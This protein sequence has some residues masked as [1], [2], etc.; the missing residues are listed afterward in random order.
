MKGEDMKRIPFFIAC[1]VVFA[2]GTN[3]QDLVKVPWS[4]FKT[5]YRENIEREIRDSLPKPEKKKP[6]PFVYT[7]DRADFNLALSRDK[8]GGRAQISGRT[9]SG[10]PERIPI[11]DE[12]VALSDIG[13]ISGGILLPADEIKGAILF[14]P[15]KNAEFRINVSFLIPVREDSRSRFVSFGTS[16]GVKNS[17]AFTLPSGCR[18]IDATGVA[19]EKGT[20]HFA[21]GESVTVRFAEEKDLREAMIPV[22]DAFTSVSIHGKR[23]FGETV[24]LPFRPVSTAFTLKL[25]QGSQYMSSSLK[26]SR[27]RR[28]DDVSYEI[29]LPPKTRDGFS[30]QFTLPES[31]KGVFS[32]TLPEIA[33]N[34][35]N[36]GNFVVGVSDGMK[37]EV[38]GNGLVS[39][40]PVSKLAEGL[41]YAAGREQYYMRAPSGGEL[42]VSAR[43]FAVGS[44]PIEIDSFTRFDFRGNRVF[45]TTVFSPVRPALSA[46]ILDLPGKSRFVSSSLENSWIK[47]LDETSYEILLPPKTTAG[48][49]VRFMVEDTDS[50]GNYSMNLPSIRTNNGKE[51]IFAI[52]EPDDL[53][54]EVSGKGLVS[55]IPVSK[56]AKKFADAAGEEQFYMSLPAGESLEVTARRYETVEAPQVVLDSVYFFTSFEENGGVMSILRMTVP[57]G[58]GRRLAVEPLPGAEIWSVMVNGEKR[59]AYADEAGNWIIPLA[60]NKSSEVEFSFLRKNEKLGLHGKIVAELPKTWLPARNVHVGVAMPARVQLLSL[61]GP[62]NPANGEKWEMPAS[63]IGQRYFF[64]RSFYKGEGMKLSI[65]YKEPVSGEIVR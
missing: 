2:T 41:R 17:L 21:A 47:K 53:R 34:A 61:E 38:S 14:L 8:A 19:D 49:S 64:S 20:R 46:F 5:I 22:I 23:I 58:A 48:F 55:R 40:I 1:I 43:R 36:E 16:P 10:E 3:A 65:Y 9:I 62:A 27:I 25:P 4:E 60:K 59:N 56:L 35:G 6:E 28:L 51:G 57:N 12:N 50:S 54:V 11:F 15:E 13:E 44:V 63:F 7:I 32:F 39:N 26:G 30:F 18:L 52:A 45:G 33:G 24:F 29:A 37:M 42:T 31:E